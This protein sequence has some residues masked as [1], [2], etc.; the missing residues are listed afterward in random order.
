MRIL[1]SVLL[2]AACSSDTPSGNLSTFPNTQIFSGAGGTTPDKV[3]IAAMG[4]T[5]VTWASMDTTIATVTGT[6]T[7]GTVTAVKAGSTSITATAG[8][9]TVTIPLTVNMYTTAQLAAGSTAFT[10]T[11]TCAKA[12][13]HDSGGPDISPSDIGKHTD[14]QIIAATSMG[15]NPEGGD[16]SIGASNHSF[17]LAT[18]DDQ[19][20]ICAYL[21]ALPPGTPVQDN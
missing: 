15:K 14:A 12:G 4:A 19:A 21:R 13:C 5:G 9:K 7:L 6:D 2:L 18:S 20:G 1:A 11:Y 17:A 16:I 3:T 8:G 10:Q